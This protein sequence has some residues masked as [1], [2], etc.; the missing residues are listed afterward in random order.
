MLNSKSWIIFSQELSVDRAS[1]AF[2]GSRG[3]R[4]L[5]RSPHTLKRSP[6]TRTKAKELLGRKPRE[7]T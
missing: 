1:D 5:S 2:E 3:Q 4:M 6:H 7:K